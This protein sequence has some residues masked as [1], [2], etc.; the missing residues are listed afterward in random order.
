MRPF[1]RC[2]VCGGELMEKEV[3]K[4]LRGG[5]HTALLKV[6]AE[7]CLHCGERVYPVETVRRFEQIRQRLER[8]DLAGFQ[9]LG[10]SFQV[11]ETV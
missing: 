3:E 6:R 11:T 2:P 9:P 4:L 5:R 10:Q 7:V 1:D 8:Q